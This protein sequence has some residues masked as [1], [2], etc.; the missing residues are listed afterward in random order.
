LLRAFVAG[1]SALFFN[2]TFS[3]AATD[4]TAAFEERSK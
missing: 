3:I 4:N 2:E 1:R